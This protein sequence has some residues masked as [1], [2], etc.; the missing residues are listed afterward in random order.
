MQ[1]K[2]DGIVTVSGD[3]LL[4]EVVNGLMKRKDWLEIRDKVTIGG[5]PGGTGNGLIKALLHNQNENSGIHEA[6][7]LIIRG[8]RSF[9]DLT[10]LKLQYHL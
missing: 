2:F 4:H 10:E 8:R 7:Y 9:M 5:I 3:G 6:A 1:D